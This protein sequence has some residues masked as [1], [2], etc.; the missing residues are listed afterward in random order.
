MAAPR[1]PFGG[2][3]G[4]RITLTGETPIGG[5]RVPNVPLPSRGPGFSRQRL[6]DIQRSLRDAEQ[7]RGNQRAVEARAELVARG[8]RAK[9]S[10]RDLEPRKLGPPKFRGRLLKERTEPLTRQRA[11]EEK[12]RVDAR[13]DEIMARPE[14]KAF[15]PLSLDAIEVE[16]A[17]ST[18]ARPVTARDVSRGGFQQITARNAPA[19]ELEARLAQVGTRE[20]TVDFK[21]GEPIGFQRTEFT[22]QVSTEQ[23]T[24]VIVFD[25]S[26]VPANNSAG[27]MVFVSLRGQGPKSLPGGGIKTFLVSSRLQGLQLIDGIRE[28]M[29]TTVLP[30]S[31]VLRPPPGRRLGPRQ[32]FPRPPITFDRLEKNSIMEFEGGSFAGTNPFVLNPSLRTTIT[33][34]GELDPDPIEG[35]TVMGGVRG[36]VRESGD[37]VLFPIDLFHEE[38]IR[39]LGIDKL[40]LDPGGE[41]QPER[42]ALEMTK[43]KGFEV[44]FDNPIAGRRLLRTNPNLRR[45]FRADQLPAMLKGRPGSP[46]PRPTSPATTPREPIL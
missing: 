9:P 26:E 41:A 33:L 23:Q 20:R 16:R 1:N 13:F 35:L 17:V 2:V 31:A 5:G 25:I 37:V 28:Q 11:A 39:T 32:I 15:A 22:F 46:S 40:L 45:L 8:K 42:F 21:V 19:Q 7:A 14:N 36:I 44:F 34:M 24:G 27:K 3:L 29:T 43:R 30:T 4:G 38:A 12:A 10:Q 6:L 18:F